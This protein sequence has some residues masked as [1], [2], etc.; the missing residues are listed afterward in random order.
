MLLSYIN[1]FDLILITNILIISFKKK[2]YGYLILDRIIWLAHQV[3][4]YHEI[5]ISQNGEFL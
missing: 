5:P 4:M 1:I 2:F 3:A